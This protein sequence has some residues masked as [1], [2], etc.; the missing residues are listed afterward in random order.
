M[1]PQHFGTFE[2]DMKAAVIIQNMRS[3]LEFARQQ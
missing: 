3:K 2:Q 1:A